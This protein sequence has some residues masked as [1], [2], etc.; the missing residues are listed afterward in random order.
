MLLAYE[1]N[2]APLAPQH[3]FPL[4]LLVPGWYGMTSVKWLGRITAVDRPFEGYQQA[5]RYRLRQDEDERRRA[6]VADAAARADGAA[7]LP[8]VPDAQPRVL[9]PGRAC[10]RGG[11]GRGW[12]RSKRVEVATDG[13]ESWG[14]AELED[15]LGSRGRGAVDVRVGARRRASTS[16]AAAPR[17][18]AGNEQPLE[19]SWNLGG[20]ANNAVQR[21][22]VTVA[23]INAG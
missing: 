14:A 4:R 21:V 18:A 8:G 12:A 1:M 13:G 16:S 15:D 17:D 11:R 5:H 23:P 9:A 7:R 19:P 10:S 2:G 6:A 20:Y 22:P 3:G